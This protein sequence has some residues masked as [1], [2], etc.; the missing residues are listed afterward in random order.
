M[1]VE[2]LAAK[3]GLEVDREAFAAADQAL[4]GLKRGWLGLAAGFTAAIVAVTGAVKATADAGDEASATAEKLGITTQALQGLRFAADLS[5]TSAESLGTALKFLQKNAIEAGKGTGDAF[6]AFKQAGVTVRD[7][8]GAVKSADVLLGD[9]A[10]HF[11][12]MPAGAEKTALALKVFGRS[13][14]EIIPLLNQ[15]QDKIAAFRAEAQ[16]LGVV[17][18]DDV[19]RN[20]NRFDD[21]TKRAAAA[22]TGL[23]NKVAA[24]LLERF[25]VLIERLAANFY[26]LEPIL[27]IVTKTVGALVDAVNWFLENDSRIRTVLFAIGTAFTA[28]A[29]SAFMALTATTSLGIA[30][31]AAAAASA[32][33]W[34]LATLPLILIGGLLFLLIED[35]AVFAAG[36]DSAIGSLIKWVDSIDPTGNPL[37][38]FFKACLSLLFDLGDPKKWDRVQEGMKGAVLGALGWIFEKFNSLADSIGTALGDIIVRALA[39]AVQ[40]I[41]FFGDQV[42][43]LLSLGTGG[44]K[45]FG[46]GAKIF[47]RGAAGVGDKLDKATGSQLGTLGSSMLEMPSDTSGLQKFGTDFLSVLADPA[48][49]EQMVRPGPT[50]S[51]QTQNTKTM[52]NAPITVTVPPGTDAAGVGLA[53]QE[54]VQQILR[55]EL[56]AA[57]GAVQGG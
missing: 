3:F 20:A 35:L 40:E 44:A 26:R 6:E 50:A 14:T 16:A 39:N 10:A 19:V 53:V 47:N 52:I 2:E 38:E 23:R 43:S 55:R 33:A 48:R 56:N 7:A 42:K 28:W 34:V 8:T 54:S 1:I 46:D 32:A 41:P 37:V 13:G 15:G 4:D 51:S 12:T 9:F 25:A 57:Y 5:D 24:P 17:M 31:L 45:L 22:L 11:E 21:A 29:L 30:S 18:G 36:G 27:L 49:F